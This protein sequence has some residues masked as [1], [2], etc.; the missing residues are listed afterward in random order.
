[1]FVTPYAHPGTTETIRV[2]VSEA[3][4]DAVMALVGDAE[5]AERVVVTDLDTGQRL[6]LSAAPC[7]GDCYCAAVVLLRETP[8]ASDKEHPRAMSFPTPSM[9]SDPAL[10]RGTP[11][12]PPMRRYP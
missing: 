8:R 6:L 9:P 3:D 11:T 2:R 1:M 5:E 12:K 7:G 10:G 4:H